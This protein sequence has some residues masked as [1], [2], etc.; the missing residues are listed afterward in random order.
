MNQIISPED[1]SSW[2]KH[3]RQS[4]QRL[5]AT[6]GCFDILHI[7]H[8]RY[9]TSAKKLGDLLIVALNDDASVQEL[10]GPTRPINPV[11]DRAEVL[12]ALEAVDVVTIF[13]GKRCNAF[14]EAAQP[15]IYVKGG[16]YK[17]V[18]DLDQSEVQSIRKYGG[19]IKL[20]DLI[21]GRSTSGI[22]EKMK[23]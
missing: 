4:G 13:S 9:L 20:L 7:G 22:I 14:L 15:D 21:P 1:L 19:E 11:H 5:V 6:N 2:R 3:I 12:V 16:D 10:K 18:E 17:G 23:Q 8:I